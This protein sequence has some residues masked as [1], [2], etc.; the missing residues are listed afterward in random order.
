MAWRYYFNLFRFT[1]A[2]GV[3]NRLICRNYRMTGGRCVAAESKTACFADAVWPEAVVPPCAVQPA[4]CA[5]FRYAADAPTAARLKKVFL[6]GLRPDEALKTAAPKHFRC[7]V[8]AWCNCR[9]SQIRPVAAAGYKWRWRA[10]RLA[11]CNN[12]PGDIRPTIPRRKRN[13]TRN[14]A[15][16]NNTG[17][18]NKASSCN[19]PRGD[20]RNNHPNR[21]SARG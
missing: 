20:I 7:P 4:R 12:S 10:G 6:L 13:C 15:C 17:N 18:N 5:V 16:C 8:W 9:Y 1:L 11:G 14:K 2:A 3:T 21:S 19:N